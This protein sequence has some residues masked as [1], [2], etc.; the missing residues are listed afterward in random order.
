MAVSFYNI[1]QEH[2][3]LK[4]ACEILQGNIL[5]ILTHVAYS[6]SHMLNTYKCNTLMITAGIF[7]ILRIRNPGSFTQKYITTLRKY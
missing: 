4:F 7:N 3:H 2:L 5:N 1:R 6:I